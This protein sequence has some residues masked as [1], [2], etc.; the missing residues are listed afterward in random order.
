MSAPSGEF[1][2]IAPDVRLGVGVR[3][4]AFINLYGCEIGD[5]TRVGTF[6][7]VQKQSTIGKRCKISSHTFICSGVTIEDEVF[8]GHGVMFIND[9]HPRATN[10]DGSPQSEADWT[11]V[12]TLVRKGASIGSN[13]T[14]LG[15]VTIG[16]RAI[17]GAGAVVTR[18]VPDDGVVAGNP[19]RPLPSKAGRPVQG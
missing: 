11:C 13:A 12:P 4:A 2:R 3:L 18:D 6:V 17:I 14:I 9:L 19:A 1:L 10:P 7:E 16:A 15:G 5:D 8:V